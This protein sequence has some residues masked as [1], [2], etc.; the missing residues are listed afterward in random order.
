MKPEER[1]EAEKCFKAH[2]SEEEHVGSLFYALVWIRNNLSYIDA[3]PELEEIKDCMD[4]CMKKVHD[5]S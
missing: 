1:I 5:R 3:F 2:M 4:K